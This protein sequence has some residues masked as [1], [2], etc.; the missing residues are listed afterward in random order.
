MKPVLVAIVKG[1]KMGAPFSCVV[2][3]VLLKLGIFCLEFC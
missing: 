3:P 1:N 2:A